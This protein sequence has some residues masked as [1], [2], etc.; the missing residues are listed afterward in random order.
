MQSFRENTYHNNSKLRLLL[1]CLITIFGFGLLYLF[2][3]FS[4]PVKVNASQNALS[5]SLGSYSA[6][7]FGVYLSNENGDDS[8]DGLSVDT[9]VKTIDK[10][11]SLAGSNKIVYVLDTINITSSV[12]GNENKTTF[13]RH[14]NFRD[15][16]IFDIS[17]DNITVENF[18]IDGNNLTT[19]SRGI[20]VSGGEEVTLNNFEVVNN[21]YGGL[22]VNNC[23]NLVLNITNSHINE[24][25][26]EEYGS[27]LYVYQS[28]N[29]TIN[30]DN[31]T[32]NNNQSKFYEN[33]SGGAIDIEESDYINFTIKN[34]QVCNNKNLNI[35]SG[36][37]LC[38]DYSQNNDV[39]IE[40]C[41]ISNNSGVQLGG[42]ICFYYSIANVK[43]VGTKISNNNATREGGAFWA[44]K[45]QTLDIISCNI[46]NNSA[47]ECG[48]VH[49]NN[50]V[51]QNTKVSIIDTRFYNNSS[52]ELINLSNSS[53]KINGNTGGGAIFS[54]ESM[55]IINCDFVGNSAVGNGGA[56]FSKGAENITIIA[57]G[58]QMNGNKV[59]D[60]SSVGGWLYIDGSV[61]DGETDTKVTNLVMSISNSQ[62]NNVKDEN[63]EYQFNGGGIHIRSCADGAHID[64]TGCE[65]IGNS[66]KNSTNSNKGGAIFLIGLRYSSIKIE[67]SLACN[68]E[69]GR[70]GGFLRISSC[71][72]SKF[73]ILNSSFISNKGVGG[74]LFIAD[75]SK[76][77]VVIV[78][79]NFDKNYGLS[80]YLY[81]SGA[82]SIINSMYEASFK[83]IDCI[84]SNNV[85]D[86]VG[87]VINTNTLQTIDIDGC[88]F[89]GNQALVGGAIFLNLRKLMNS[90]GSNLNI[91]N[92]NFIDNS[93][94]GSISISDESD[95]YDA[96][97]TVSG[98]GAIFTTQNLN[99]DSCNF[100]NNSAVGNGGAIWCY[101][102]SNTVSYE[103]YSSNFIN[104]ST[105][106]RSG[107]IETL[108]PMSIYNSYF[109]GN[110]AVGNG[111]VM[112]YCGSNFY[113]CIFTKNYSEANGGVFYQYG[114]L[115]GLY[116]C[117]LFEN[118]AKENGGAI[119]AIWNISLSN[120]NVYNNYC[121]GKGGGI[122]VNN[123]ESTSYELL[124]SND[125]LLKDNLS[126]VIFETNSYQGGVND[127]LYIQDYQPN[128]MLYLFIGESIKGEYNITFNEENCSEYLNGNVPVFNF[129]DE[130]NKQ[131]KYL[132]VLNCINEGYEFEL[133]D[134]GI[135]LKK[136]SG[137]S[138]NEI[139]YTASDYIG[140]Y[141]GKKHTIDIKTYLPNDIQPTITYS[142]S[143]DGEYSLTPPTFKNETYAEDGSQS[144]VTVYF[145]IN[146][147]GY[148]EVSGSRIVQIKPFVT[149]VIDTPVFNLPYG[150]YPNRTDLTKY[151]VSGGVFDQNG[152]KIDGQFTSNASNPKFDFSRNEITIYFYPTNSA[153]KGLGIDCTFYTEY[154][155]LWFEGGSFY[156]NE[157]CTENPI[158]MSEGL[159]VIINHMA[160]NGVIHFKSTYSVTSNLTIVSEKN[161]TLQR[162]VSSEG[163]SDISIFTI[164][165]GI[166]LSIGSYDMTGKIVID[167][168]SGTNV[169]NPLINNAGTLNI[170][171]NVILQNG[172]N[173]KSVATV[174]GGAIYSSG[175]LNLDFTK[176]DNCKAENITTASSGGAIYNDGGSVVVKNLTISNCVAYGGAAIYSGGGS[177]K[178]LNVTFDK[179]YARFD[180][181]V[182]PK[183]FTI[184]IGGGEFN[185]NNI[186]I[187]NSSL[188]NSSG[189]SQSSSSSEFVAERN[190]GGI[191]IAN[192][193]TASILNSEFK[194]CLA[195]SGGGIY[196]DG[197]I[198]LNGVN[199]LSCVA[200]S[201]NGVAIALGESSTCEILNCKLDNEKIVLSQSENGNSIN[202][203]YQVSEDSE[204]TVLASG[205]NFDSSNLASVGVSVKGNNVSKNILICAVICLVL[206]FGFATFLV[207]KKK[208]K[209]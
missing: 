47:K 81:A 37:G 102:N 103:V 77:E 68:N 174:K 184:F 50:L 36:G 197:V 78:G 42:G 95:P 113:N 157:E 64:I 27:G 38:F 142:L 90:T 172:Y 187:S 93:A 4:L 85:C 109:E 104:N 16:I 31:C 20:S 128:R 55:E 89:V 149:Y 73:N 23:P 177:V 22:I 96:T 162:Y 131:S 200:K 60:T 74:A 117:I 176:I 135:Y 108:R 144:Q 204:I 121:G 57:D 119:V 61:S 34:S 3:A 158:P 100:E 48:G 19:S 43:I 49:I 196:C 35:Y 114:Y 115:L 118:F 41:D 112:G 56:I 180:S 188:I 92:S 26:A 169:S 67:D 209:K 129:S 152:N 28:D 120:T 24:N 63:G 151:L 80:N 166:T 171:G 207:V 208:L 86:G 13:V 141:D 163:V 175:T 159:D 189:S 14:S 99:I 70:Y 164:N 18:I 52:T 122:F 203:V 17:G 79:S 161:I 132:D 8:N 107:A 21:N 125:N 72:L 25:V 7:D 201:G 39:L 32:F 199:F 59:T 111:G 110:H 54:S 182:N 46:I 105:Q 195:Y 140:V 148:N 183:G 82:I 130:N 87:G 124:L 83:L 165:S 1:S 139:P 145:K 33:G 155:E 15:G 97:G 44:N 150:N 106:G 53:Y 202:G 206:I 10:A 205:D 134:D 69:T 2:F 91:T 137:L 116:N 76:S 179:N 6:S 156:T 186:L 146:A 62:I 170:Y 198:S 193:A 29:S 123:R 154:S 133:R 143:Q 71:D 173:N 9:P 51:E 185:A 181:G 94:T 153:Y 178:L 98:G 192:G 194:S 190:G 11:I 88:S 160:Q 168:M 138:Q 127:N 65:I 147:D 191:Y 84:F 5:N 45:L 58:N 66:L 40:N 167:G 101:I 136:V 30:I 126:G 75:S 12:S